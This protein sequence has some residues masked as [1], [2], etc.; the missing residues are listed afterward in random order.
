MYITNIL[1]SRI[2]LWMFIRSSLVV[3]VAALSTNLHTAQLIFR[4]VT[5]IFFLC[6]YY[7]KCHHSIPT[8]ESPFLEHGSNF[9]NSFHRVFFPRQ[10]FKFLT[11]KML[12]SCSRI[13]SHLGGKMPIKRNRR[14]S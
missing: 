11:N 8:T 6:L 9:G 10:Q 2:K 13:V 14:E 1:Y 3:A 4:K 5:F 7:C 12:W